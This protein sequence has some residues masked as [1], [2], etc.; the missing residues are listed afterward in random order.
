MIAD[1]ENDTLDTV[2]AE[3]LN[4]PG[5]KQDV[6]VKVSVRN[7][8]FYYGQHQVL[9][10]NNIDIVEHKVTAIIGPSG[11]G[12]STHIRAYNRVYELYRDQR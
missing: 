4:R 8:D 11:C 12:K 1:T 10:N 7:L 3:N 5:S 6:T 2:V 9:F